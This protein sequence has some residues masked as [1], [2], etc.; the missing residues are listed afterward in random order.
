MLS[1]GFKRR[2]F[3][4][5]YLLA[6]ASTIIMLRCRRAAHSGSGVDATRVIQFAPVWYQ[7]HTHHIDLKS[8][9]ECGACHS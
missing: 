9:D 8:L 2:R 1:P 3:A 4:D 6:A 5:H 7:R